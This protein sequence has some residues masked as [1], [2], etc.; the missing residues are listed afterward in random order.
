MDNAIQN[1]RLAVCNAVESAHTNPRSSF[2]SLTHCWD[3][4]IWFSSDVGSTRITTECIVRVK[5]MMP[6]FRGTG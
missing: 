4:V 5:E 3:R 6:S 1:W 2:L